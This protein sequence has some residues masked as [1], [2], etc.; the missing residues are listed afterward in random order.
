MLGFVIYLLCTQDNDMLLNFLA[1]SIQSDFI[2]ESHETGSGST[3]ENLNDF[4]VLTTQLELMGS[5]L[6]K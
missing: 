2:N 1:D 6:I 5:H 4:L 3:I